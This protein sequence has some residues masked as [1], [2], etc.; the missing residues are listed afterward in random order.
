MIKP[1]LEYHGIMHAMQ[2]SKQKEQDKQ[3]MTNNTY[4]MRLFHYIISFPPRHGGVPT[5]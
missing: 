3:R 4:H 2:P 1:S 5:T